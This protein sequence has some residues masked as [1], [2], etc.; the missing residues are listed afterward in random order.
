[1]LLMS[2]MFDFFGIM[3]FLYAFSFAGT[4]VRYVA[5]VSL[6]VVGNC[7]L[8]FSLKMVLFCVFIS[9]NL[10]FFFVCMCVW[11]MYIVDYLF[12]VSSISFA[13]RFA[14]LNFL[15]GLFFCCSNCMFVMLDV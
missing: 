4:F 11:L 14:S 5:F 8:C 12:C 15:I 13:R 3:R 7:L 10:I 6:F 2:C 1:M 9:L